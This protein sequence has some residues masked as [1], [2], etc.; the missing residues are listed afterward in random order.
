ME[1]CG[2]IYFDYDNIEKDVYKI[3]A[4]KGANIARYRLWHDPKW[5]N[6]SN[7]SDLKN[8]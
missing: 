8:L 1:D 5:T 4:N 3:L 6:Y 2:A 7:L